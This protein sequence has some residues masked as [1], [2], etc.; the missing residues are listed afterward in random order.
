MPG[1]A[2][3]L[4]LAGCEENSPPGAASDSATATEA[5]TGDGASGDGPTADRPPSGEGRDGGDRPPSDGD[6][7]PGPPP[8]EPHDRPLSFTQPAVSQ[9]QYAGPNN[10]HVHISATSASRVDEPRPAGELWRECLSVRFD[11]RPDGCHGETV[12]SPW[13]QFGARIERLDRTQF[14]GGDVVTGESDRHFSDHGTHYGEYTLRTRVRELPSTGQPAQV[15]RLV[16]TVTDW[17][18]YPAYLTVNTSEPYG[19]AYLPPGTEMETGTLIRVYGRAEDWEDDYDEAHEEGP[20]L[21]AEA[22]LYGRDRYD[23]RLSAYSDYWE[24]DDPVRFT[25][26]ISHWVTVTRP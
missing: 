16:T 26:V 1:L 2:V 20:R 10:N 8:T 24:M 21:L 5:G 6:S 15:S 25:V 14:G 22:E 12:R 11:R 7:E 17:E 18:G 19:A 23:F 13:E 9:L 4:A 3:V